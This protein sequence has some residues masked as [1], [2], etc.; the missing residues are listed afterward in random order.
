MS[1]QKILPGVFQE[2]TPKT[3]LNAA[4][5][6]AAWLRELEIDF[7]DGK[8]WSRTPEVADEEI[9]TET[10]FT[11]KCLYGGSAGIG[12]YFLRLYDAT[13]E[14][15]YLKE[16]EAAASHILA[17][18]PGKAFYSGSSGRIRG[19]A[20]GV[21]N[22]LVGEA[23]FVEQLYEKLP[24]Q[25]YLD[26]VKRVA[27]DL[28]EVAES[29]E[30][31][32]HWSDSSDVPADGGIIAF[33][34]LAYRRFGDERYLRTAALG[35]DY[36]A[37][38]AVDAP[39][40]GKYFHLF[41]ETKI[42]FPKGTLFPSFTHGTAGAGW[43]LAGLY[44]ETK[45]EKYLQLAKDAAAFIT[46]IAVGD[47][48]GALI[49]HLYNPVTGPTNEQFY[50]ST[51]GGP[52]GTTLLFRLLYEVTGEREYLGWIRRLARGIIRT[53]A[54]EKNSWGYWKSNCLC[55]GAPGVLEH[56]VSVYEL[57]GEQEFLEYA[58]RTANV[59]LSDS[60]MADQKRRWY[61][62]WSRAK[63]QDVKSYTGLYV[64]SSGAAATLLRFYGAQTGREITPFYEYLL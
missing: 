22:G 46:S 48:D 36:L 64:G 1:N 62:A 61:G 26:F 3:Y 47:E 44:K 57:T 11:E 17:T 28:L 4:V 58:Q 15:K 41:D 10:L 53:G 5:E 37:E 63:P 43:V 45:D 25:E 8:A 60:Y 52:P 18:Y 30:N 49:P 39:T 23:Y 40:G 31:G 20:L 29:D 59:L 38:K 51:C 9:E 12:I 34:I 14:E 55:C 54:P 24:K 19:W 32:I 27:D 7:P 16:A 21:Y 42:G 2:N 6:T 13:G 33:L 50:L 56:F 35:G